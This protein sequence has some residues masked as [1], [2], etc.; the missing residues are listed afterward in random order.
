M[1]SDVAALLP[2]LA[3]GYPTCYVF[4][5]RL[6]R[7]GGRSW[8]TSL[9]WAIPGAL[10]I[11]SGNMVFVSSWQEY[12]KFGQAVRQTLL[13]QVG[14]VLLILAYFFLH[15]FAVFLP[16]V[17]WSIYEQIRRHRPQPDIRY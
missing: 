8:W 3:A 7:L 6:L 11:L 15:A 10:M 12:R 17:G 16:V 4:A 5:V 14:A 1:N 9:R 13:F 2:I